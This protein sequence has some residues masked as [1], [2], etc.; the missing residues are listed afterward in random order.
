MNTLTTMNSFYKVA[1]STP[2]PTDPNHTL[3]SP[4]VSYAFRTTD[5]QSGTTRVLNIADG[6]YD[7]SYNGAI[8]RE[9][10]GG[11]TV[12]AFKS[13]NGNL[14]TSGG[15]YAQVITANKFITSSTTYTAI[16]FSFWIYPTSWVQNQAGNMSM[17]IWGGVPGGNAS[18]VLM[19][20]ITGA[21]NTS[22]KG[23]LYTSNAG[24]ALSATD[25]FSVNT[26]YHVA[27]V[28][29]GGAP[30]NSYMYLNGSST[31]SITQTGTITINQDRSAN[32]L[33]IFS[34]GFHGWNDPCMQGYICNFRVYSR[35]LTSAEITNIYNLGIKD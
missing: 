28:V 6:T 13:T 20:G 31:A 30:G 26:W 22:R 9:T 10:V 17:F 29:K 18:T 14:R 32:P 5:V 19:A 16:T 27:V 1:K 25:V 23:K 24:D 3:Y 11:R 15:H 4:I 12:N 7:L 35:E 8:V 34:N 21:S 2:P 33:C